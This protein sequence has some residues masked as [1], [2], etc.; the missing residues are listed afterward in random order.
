LR[1]ILGRQHGLVVFEQLVE[2]GMSSQAV[3][4]RRRS[5]E[6]ER[7]FPRV[8]RSPFVP[9]SV[10]QAAMAAVLW[11]GEGS[12]ASHRT[13]AAL[14]GIAGVEHGARVELWVPGGRAPRNAAVV[15]HRGAV[16]GN[17]RRLVDRVPVTSAARTI[18]DLA[19]CFEG[20]V[21]EAALEDVLHRGLTTP[22]T[23]ERRLVSLGGSGRA[24]ARRLRRLLAQ[25]DEAPAGSRLEVRVWRLLRGA[26]LR[27]VRQYAVRCEGRRFRL[28]FAWPNLKVAVEAEGFVAHGGR[29]AHVADR[30]RLAALV[31]AGWSIVPV[32][33]DDCTTEP[34]VFIERVRAAL[35]RA[36]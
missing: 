26:G 25:R 19:G 14:W 32:T 20:E 13:G 6:L 28:D 17:D 8:Y 33:W 2:L 12:V 9:P 4:R 11:A 18:I 27:P 34:A 30:R 10:A 22:A 16:T 36:A 7:V 5:G 23:I 15:V 35:L 29:V 1:A 31:A 3:S 24:G 21:L